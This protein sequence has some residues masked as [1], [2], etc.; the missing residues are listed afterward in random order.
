MALKLFEPGKVNASNLQTVLKEA[1]NVV[2]LQDSNPPLEVT[3]H[4][5]QVYDVGILATTP[6]RAFISMKLIPG[7]RT[8]QTLMRRYGAKGMPWQIAARCLRQVLVPLAFM[9][10]EPRAMAHGDIQPN[11]ESRAMAH[12]DIKPNNVLLDQSDDLVLADFGLA[13]IMPLSAECGCI[14]YLAPEGLTG[15][16]PRT[17]ADLYSVG[18]VWYE[19]LTSVHPYA[20]AGLEAIAAGDDRAYLYA[21]AQARHWPYRSTEAGETAGVGHVV[22]VSDL[23]PELREHPQL[24]A[25]LRRCLEWSPAKRYREAG[26]LLAE[27]DRYL[28]P[29]ATGP[30]APARAAAGQVT[31]PAPPA[32]KPLDDADAEL[33]NGRPGAALRLA[34][35]ARRHEPQSVRAM[36]V[37]LAAL[38]ALGRHNEAR[39]RGAEAYRRWPT[40][41]KVGWAYSDAIEAAGQRELAEQMRKQ[42][43]GPR[44]SSE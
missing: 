17:Q 32:A 9:H 38:S 39:Q 33:K 29:D 7:R 8:L 44:P 42:L 14:E 15:A 34:Q 28:G 19:M 26:E 24:E 25:M 37:E 21:H 1:V 16:E 23:V 27:L 2:W 22:P 4:L 3:R 12:G 35:E 11:A 43:R 36:L 40:D 31:A 13:E 5:L 20:Q 41:L 6:A 30:S 18:V 10:A